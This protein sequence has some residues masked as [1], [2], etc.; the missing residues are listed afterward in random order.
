MLQMLNDI[1]A[2]KGDPGMVDLLFE[3]IDTMKAASE[4]PV[5]KTAP[6]I[7]LFMLEHFRDQFEAHILEK[8][9]PFGICKEVITYK[10]I[11]P[12]RA[13]KTE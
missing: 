11:C 7:V 8:A 2:G 3:L 10:T 5:G 12:L 4:C 13:D 9:C 1:A 6:D